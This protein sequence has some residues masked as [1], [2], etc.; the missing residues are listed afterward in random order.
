MSASE[1]RVALMPR[2]CE[3]NSK[4]HLKTGATAALRA[5]SGS[6]KRAAGRKSR[7]F[8]ISFFYISFIFPSKRAYLT[9]GA[10]RGVS[11]SDSLQ[12]ET[13]DDLIVSG[14]P[15]RLPRIL[16]TEKSIKGSLATHFA[17]GLRQ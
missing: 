13:G 11:P 5:D 16:Q 10:A 6:L 14:F 4:V 17:E 3:V 1:P 7:L 12:I 15:P 9:R 2:G 8:F